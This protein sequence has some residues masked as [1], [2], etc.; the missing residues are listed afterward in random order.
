MSTNTSVL[1]IVDTTGSM[2][3][4]LLSLAPSLRQIISIMQVMM[5]NAKVGFCAY[6]D[7]DQ[8]PEVVRFLPYT[9][10]L[11]AILDFVSTLHPAGGGDGPEATKTALTEIL[12]IPEMLTSETVVFL[13][14]DAP[15]HTLENGTGNHKNHTMEAAALKH[16]DWGTLVKSVARTGARFF[17][18]VSVS[19]FSTYSYFLYL[20]EM[21]NGACFMIRELR[22]E[23]ITSLTLAIFQMLM[24]FSVELP[25]DCVQISYANG[26]VKTEDGDEKDANGYFSS[27]ARSEKQTAMSTSVTLPILEFLKTDTDQLQQR[28]ERTSEGDDYRDRVFRVFSLLV[29]VDDIV[30]LAN[31]AALGT[32]W[33]MI[34]KQRGDERRD[35]LVGAVG[36]VINNLASEEDRVFVRAWLDSSYNRTEEIRA[37]VSAVAQPYPM[38]ILAAPVERLQRAD[39]LEISRVCNPATLSKVTQIITHLQ[40]VASASV[41]NS[42]LLPGAYVPLS[43][44]SK[45]VFC[46]LPHLMAEGLEF[47]LR[48]AAILATLIVQVK[49]HFLYERASEFLKSIR[50]KWIDWK[51]TPENYGVGFCQL[52]LR[53]PSQVYLSEEERAVMR[54]VV[55]TAGLRYNFKSVVPCRIKYTPSGTRSN[56][57][58]VIPD[59]RVKC[60]KCHEDR[61]FTLMT[62]SGV[63]GPC[64]SECVDIGKDMCH[65]RPSESQMA[66]C[67]ACRA[68]YSVSMVSALLSSPK[69]HFCRLASAALNSSSDAVRPTV[70]CMRCTNEFISPSQRV[71][72]GNFECARCS[73]RPE[74]D[75]FD[76]VQV[77]VLE[78][79]LTENGANRSMILEHVGLRPLTDA[80]N[81]TTD[82]FAIVG[83]EERVEYSPPAERSV[84]LYRGQSLVWKNFSVLNTEEVLQTIVQLVESGTAQRQTC[85]IC[86]E[87][88]RTA[89]WM[90]ACGGK[91]DAT[92]CATCLHS[93]YSANKLGCI[94]YESH[95]LCPFCKQRPR[96]S[97]LRRFHANLMHARRPEAGLDPRFHH[98]WCRR[99]LHVVPYAAHECAEAVPLLN[100]DFM[101]TACA[102]HVQ[103][104]PIGTVRS[105]QRSDSAAERVRECPGC[106]VMTEKIGG[107]CNHITCGSCAIH[108]CFQCSA[109]CRYNA[110]PDADPDAIA[111][112]D[113]SA[114]LEDIYDHMWSTHGSIGL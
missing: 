18:L 51:T 2:G 108:W 105:G 43:L 40:E 44:S 112:S 68:L 93:W 58:A 47:S 19:T 60:T 35:S 42:D 1:F 98:A 32:M 94:F 72:A 46:L 109:I 87:H 57:L 90:G 106:G 20:S 59:Y 14:T 10:D 54:V 71:D 81:L 17:S 102:D 21:T 73:L 28:F 77:P 30:A 16:L 84:A 83:V 75:P 111:N 56:T 3:T 63:C 26:F 55:Q 74:L 38:V 37:I 4:Y 97:I 89:D 66:R 67:T 41:R 24:G 8:S 12:N 95:A 69:C 91:C 61:S 49:Q 6:S 76:V 9:D 22:K 85:L 29:N 79:L 99:C 110:D 78:L 45:Q 101:C 33:R 103:R 15:P 88:V 13:M 31:N 62:E 34:C 96:A 65:G 80:V 25:G 53:G 100:G 50:G 7:Y 64:V 5:P 104:N 27:L 36:G 52:M 70:K 86:C 113:A 23:L 107:T 114:L 11:S 82:S 48:A 39:L 92:A